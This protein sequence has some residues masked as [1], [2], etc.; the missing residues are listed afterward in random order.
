MNFIHFYF[1]HFHYIIF[2][3]IT[4][5]KIIRQPPLLLQMFLWSW[6]IKGE[7]KVRFNKV[8]A[9][10]KVVHLSSSI[11]FTFHL[12]TKTSSGQKY[13]WCLYNQS[14]ER[15]VRS[16]SL[17]LWRNCHIK[18]FNKTHGVYSYNGW[19]CFQHGCMDKWR[20]GD[21]SIQIWRIP[22]EAFAWF[23]YLFSFIRRNETYCYLTKP[24]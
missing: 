23:T 2:S 8:E 9:M 17:K 16:E 11:T 10:L 1:I 4:Y 15:P 22:L 6:Y 13:A 18:A 14:S 7:V 12:V 3:T 19:N 21:F 20:S 5:Y 24:F